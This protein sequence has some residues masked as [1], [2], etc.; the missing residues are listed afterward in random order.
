MTASTTMTIRVSPEVKQKLD[1]IATDTRRS[2][3]FLAGEAVAAY[4]EREL[5]IIDGIKRGMADA[6]A[7]RVIPHDQAVAEMRAVIEDAK[8]R[9]A[10]QG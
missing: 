2:K 9:K 6:A 5:E 10:A 3:S 4:V 1:R 7:G 8:R